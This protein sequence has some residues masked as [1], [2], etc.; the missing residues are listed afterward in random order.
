MLSH[1]R[2]IRGLF[3]SFAALSVAVYAAIFWRMPM[4]G[5]DFAFPRTHGDTGWGERLAWIAYK[6]PSHTAGWNARFG[7]QLAIV[8]LNLPA[9]MFWLVSLAAFVAFNALIA[10]VYSGR[11]DLTLKLALSLGLMF[12]LWP[13][14]E[15]FFWKTANAGYLQPI[16]LSLICIVAYRSET[17][18]ASMSRRPGAIA[19]LCLVGLC[20]GYSFENVPLALVLYMMLAWGLSPRR[21]EMWPALLPVVAVLIGWATLMT[22]PSTA[23]RRAYYAEVFGAENPDLTY[24]LHRAEEV[25]GTFFDTS[26]L[27]FALALVS[28]VFLAVLQRRGWVKIDRRAWWTIMPAVLVVGSMMAA[29]YTEPRAFS[30]AWALM[31]AVVVEAAW[32]TCQRWRWAGAIWVALLAISAGFAIKTLVIYEDVSDT[33]QAR[34]MRILRHLD[35]PSCAEGLPI[36]QRHF[37]YAYRYFNNRDDWYLF[38]LPQVGEYYSCKLIPVK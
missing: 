36:R 33:F 37:N 24:Y 25:T 20:A 14:L 18:L 8:W 2:A 27:L 9:W 7:E 16:V 13:G 34:E 11:R 35:T 21:R 10:M 29:P 22:M 5:E 6:I 19:G 3:I 12:A 4:M 30:L 32:Q 28:L 26:A 15:I 23:H 1:C 17:T 38:A 31:F